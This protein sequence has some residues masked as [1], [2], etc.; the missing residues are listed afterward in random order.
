M[1][2]TIPNEPYQRIIGG[3][4]CLFASKTRM[5]CSR[6]SRYLGEKYGVTSIEISKKLAKR[7]LWIK[8]KICDD[9]KIDSQ[10][11]FVGDD[12]DNVEANF[13]AGI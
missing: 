1:L 4:L 12:I 9:K 3:G 6:N 2:L 11:A 7:K 10:K 5:R 8:C 13:E